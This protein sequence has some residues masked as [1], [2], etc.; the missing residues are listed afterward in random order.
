MASKEIGWERFQHK[1]GRGYRPALRH[2]V[3]K[4]RFGFRTHRTAC[5]RQEELD[6]ILETWRQEVLVVEMPRCSGIFLLK[7]ML[8]MWLVMKTMVRI[9]LGML[10]TLRRRRM[11]KMKGRN[12]EFMTIA[13]CMNLCLRV[14]A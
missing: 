11:N 4:S 2:M 13:D 3:L 7:T 5:R 6:R 12:L 14:V 10:V 1:R 9:W 8:R